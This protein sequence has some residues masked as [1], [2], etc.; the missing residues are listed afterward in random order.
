MIEPLILK[1]FWLSNT[2]A[3]CIDESIMC[4]IRTE[5]H[6][7]FQ[8]HFST[9]TQTSKSLQEDVARLGQAMYSRNEVDYRLDIIKKN[10]IERIDHVQEE[11]DSDLIS[12]RR[13]VNQLKET[14]KK[15]HQPSEEQNIGRVLQ[16][17]QS[18]E[19]TSIP[20]GDDFL[21]EMNKRIDE[22]K[23]TM[24]QTIGEAAKEATILANERFD[25]FK[26]CVDKS[27]TVL[28]ERV[29]AQATDSMF[30]KCSQVQHVQASMQKQLE[31]LE[32]ELHQC[33]EELECIQLGKSSE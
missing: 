13:V 22:L 28:Q 12:H 8:K 30:A 6:Q 26:A 25:T 2:M 20:R 32:R 29:D 17:L 31:R 18:L 4:A 15:N 19:S 5:V 1:L 3:R 10:L 24:L 27:L 16:P 21:N 11:C 7:A 9:L 33:K 23:A 14:K